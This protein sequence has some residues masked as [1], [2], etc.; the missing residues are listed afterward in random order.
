MA[1]RKPTKRGKVRKKVDPTAEVWVSKDPT[2]WE[3]LLA[4]ARSIPR[5]SLEKMPADL[6]RN[7]DHYLDGSPKQ[8]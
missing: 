7:A 2:L 4:I 8:E 3:D 1:I 5:E 6:G